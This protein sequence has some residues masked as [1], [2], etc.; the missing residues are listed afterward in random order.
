[1]EDHV[2]IES[3]CKLFSLDDDVAV[4]TGGSGV[5]CSAIALGLARAGARVA[6]LNRN[7]ENAYPIVEKINEIGGTALACTCDVTDRKSV[8][9]AYE[10]VIDRFKRVDILV[11]GAGGNHPDAI[12]NP[13]KRFFEIPPEAMT[14][15]T[16]LNLL[17][18]ILP[19]QVFGAQ[20]AQQNS[21]VILNITSMSAYR[22]L[23]RVVAYGAAKAAVSN[24][25][26][27]LAVHLAQE[28]STKI[29]VNAL[30][31]GFYLG[32]QNRAL[33]VEEKTGKLT[34]RGKAIL[35]H[36][37]MARFGNPEDL[38]GAALWLVSPASAFVTGIVVPVDGGFNAYAGV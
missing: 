13:K 6:L 19:C 3:I 34:D 17:G 1:L 4:V 36:T 8:E 9:A 10:A 31:P 33:L 28:Y 24:F 23:T 27:W 29:R 32:N 22:P 16:Q 35:A 11:N 18:T 14:W 21:G 12:A 2:N 25:T 37:P 26:Q 7:V 5:L 15:V 38:V 30:A 20:M